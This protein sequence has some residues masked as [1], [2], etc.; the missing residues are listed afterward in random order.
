[1]HGR[2]VRKKSKL[3]IPLPQTQNDDDV[4]PDVAEP[5]SSYTR[6]NPYF[7]LPSTSFRSDWPPS[8]LSNSYR[9]DPPPFGLSNVFRSDLSP[10]HKKM[11]KEPVREFLWQDVHRCM[12]I[13]D[14]LPKQA[15]LCEHT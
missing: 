5:T 4:S 13:K 15:C 1:M 10:D 11:D 7:A 3:T 14:F 12:D 6:W 9:S 2:L 8:G